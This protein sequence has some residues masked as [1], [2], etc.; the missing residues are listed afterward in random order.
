MRFSSRPARPRP[1]PPGGPNIHPR[2]VSP[3]VPGPVPFPRMD[4]P[5][6]RLGAVNL[7][8]LQGPIDSLVARPLLVDVAIATG[9]TLLSIVTVFGGATDIGAAGGGIGFLFLL[10][11]TAPLA[12]R[13]IW[14]VPVW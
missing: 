3:A 6:A 5:S 14:P 8:V 10:L 11:E 2:T 7:R 13:R 1:H 9:L 4:E 12:V